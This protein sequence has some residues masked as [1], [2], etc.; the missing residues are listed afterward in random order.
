MLSSERHHC[1]FEC[2]T[3]KRLTSLDSYV[4]SACSHVTCKSCCSQEKPAA[5]P[6]CRKQVG[7][8][9]SLSQHQ[10]LA[11]RVLCRVKVSCP[12]RKRHNCTWAGDY[13]NLQFHVDSHRR[14][15]RSSKG[16]VSKD[17][18]KLTQQLSDKMIDYSNSSEPNDG[19][20][21]RAM[22]IGK[23]V[24]STGTAREQNDGHLA[25]ASGNMHARQRSV[26]GGANGR[27]DLREQQA[28]AKPIRRCSSMGFIREQNDGNLAPV[29]SNT[30]AR[31]RSGHGDSNGSN[32]LREQQAVAMPIRRCSS[33]DFMT[34]AAQ[35][36]V[37]AVARRRNSVDMVST[38]SETLQSTSADSNPSD[39]GHVRAE[40]SLL[41]TAEKPASMTSEKRESRPGIRHVQSE[42]NAGD[43]AGKRI[44]LVKQLSKRGLRNKSDA[45]C[46]DERTAGEGARTRRSFVK[47]ISNRVQRR[48]SGADCPEKS[49]TNDR[50]ESDA[51]CPDDRTAGEGAGMRRSFVKQISNRVLG[52]NSDA[53][54][55]EKSSTNDRMLARSCKGKASQKSSTN[56]R[57]LARSCKGKAS[58]AF[59]GGYFQAAIGFYTDAIK[60]LTHTNKEGT[61]VS[62]LYAH[63]AEAHL[64]LYQYRDCI[65]DSEEASRLDYNNVKAYL[66]KSL[67]HVELGQFEE[68]CTT[69]SIGLG[70]IPKSSELQCEVKLTKQLATTMKEVHQCMGEKNYEGVLEAT[71]SLLELQKSNKHVLLARGN[72]Y[73]S[74][75]QA[76]KAIKEANDVVVV[77]D[78]TYTAALEI[79]TKAHYLNGSFEDALMDCQKA[80][81]IAPQCESIEET[82]EMVRRVEQLFADA[83]RSTSNEAYKQAA[84]LYGKAIHAAEPLPMSTELYR[85]LY[86]ARA[87]AHLQATNHMQALADANLVLESLPTY[88]KAWETKIKILEAT[89]RFQQLADD[90][91]GVVGPGSWGCQ[92]RIL[93]EAYKRAMDHFKG[94]VFA[95]E[96][97][98][99]HYKLLG[100]DKNASID[101]IR[102]VYRQKARECHPDKFLTATDAERTM[103]KNKFKALQEIMDVLCDVR[104]RHQYDQGMV[105]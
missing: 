51:D 38:F 45:G 85:I 91:K 87:E 31:Q 78:N 97:S 30:Y 96:E 104:C 6:S 64:R 33:M 20:S 11:Y 68:A 90:L 5:C 59:R 22:E 36:E 69:L 42:R 39:I 81:G 77:G 29:S 71:E 63:R 53:D 23:V 67:A 73:L 72:A 28:A 92:H 34:K 46:L 14:A 98:M 95:E 17:E 66:R 2:A 41:V 86:L 55:P 93:V 101:E 82:Y 47:K 61:I 65:N 27:N 49:S 19:K 56:D 83:E 84:S 15:N 48:N 32:D 40:E 76:D 24:N 94:P 18:K 89:E 21:E 74:L 1:E 62:S 88:V 25:R 60:A 102:K 10:P 9:T 43:G 37:Y 99:D 16:P 50:I 26:H 57:M 3:C 54:C 7:A 100:V 75:N 70:R 12:L 8:L 4:F 105:T 13:K 35:Q 103:A 44:S 52:K 58:R 79:R 80:L